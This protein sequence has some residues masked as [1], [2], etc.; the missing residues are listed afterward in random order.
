M[1]II[2]N[3]EK[4]VERERAR[5]KSKSVQS[6]PTVVESSMD[7][8]AKMRP[9]IGTYLDRW[10]A[11]EVWL[12]RASKHRRYYTHSLAL[13]RPEMGQGPPSSKLIAPPCDVSDPS[14]QLITCY[15]FIT[16]ARLR[17]NEQWMVGGWMDG[18]R[19]AKGV[20]EWFMLRGYL[21]GGIINFGAFLE[22]VSV[23]KK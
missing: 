19:R 21:R 14:R 16:S 11:G 12:R 4:Q 6:G 3:P 7:F 5:G 15:L 23:E 13:L 10:M 17:W 20:V 1:V 8:M 18:A 22:P 9:L 2:V